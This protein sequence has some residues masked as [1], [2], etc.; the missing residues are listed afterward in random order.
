V[1]KQLLLYRW[2]GEEGRRAGSWLPFGYG[3]RM[4]IGYGFALQEMK[5]SNMRTEFAAID[6]R[7]CKS[8]SHVRALQEITECVVHDLLLPNVDRQSAACLHQSWVHLWRCSS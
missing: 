7:A 1:V 3:P 8:L 6:Y 5:V 4:C 2:L